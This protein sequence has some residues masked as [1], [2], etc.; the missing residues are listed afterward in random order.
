VNIGSRYFEVTYTRARSAAKAN[1]NWFTKK[2]GSSCGI[3]F[4]QYIPYKRG[5][6]LLPISV[7]AWRLPG[8]RD[9]EKQG[10]IKM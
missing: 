8:G 9:T 5:Y 1:R 10:I 3:V 2:N 4:I 6:R 7:A